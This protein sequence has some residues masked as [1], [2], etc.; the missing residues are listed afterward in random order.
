MSPVVTMP[1]RSSSAR[2]GTISTRFLTIVAITSAIGVSGDTDLGFLVTI[3]V[4]GCRSAFLSVS[5]SP[6]FSRYGD[7]SRDRSLPETTPTNT[8]FAPSSVG[9]SITGTCRTLLSFMKFRHVS[10]LSSRVSVLTSLVM[11][12]LATRTKRKKTSFPAQISSTTSISLNWPFDMRLLASA[13]QFL[14][15]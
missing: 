3:C 7:I 2:T 1:T 5:F 9:G 13:G 11:M 14:F 4:S 10:T 12:S 8:G 6:T 15:S